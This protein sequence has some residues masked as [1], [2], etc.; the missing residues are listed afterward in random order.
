MASSG[1][2][3]LSKRHSA[4]QKLRFQEHFHKVLKNKIMRLQRH[5]KRN[6]RMVERKAKK[7]R[8]VKVDQQAINRLKAIT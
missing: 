6:A 4:R 3:G 8:V 1:S 5:V 2:K 7:G